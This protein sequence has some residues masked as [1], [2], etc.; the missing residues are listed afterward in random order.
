MVRVLRSLVRGPLESVA[1]GFAEELDRCG[2]TRS[3]AEQ[4][5]CFVA[6]LDRWMASERMGVADLGGPAIERYLQQRRAVGYEG[7]CSTKAMRPLL[8]YLESLG[9]L[10][11]PELVYLG[12]VVV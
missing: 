2:Y 4:H 8:D 11:P 6:H 1:I 3:S 7:Y 5:V 9:V 10:P 12:A